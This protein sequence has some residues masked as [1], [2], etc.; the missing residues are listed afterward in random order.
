MSW[1]LSIDCSDVQSK[2]ETTSTA[3]DAG[4]PAAAC[5]ADSLIAELQS[6][7]AEAATIAK[8]L[9]T[10]VSPAAAGTVRLARTPVDRESKENRTPAPPPP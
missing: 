8:A 5:S 6:A 7:Q 3:D 2:A 4:L 1:K 9:S 10:G